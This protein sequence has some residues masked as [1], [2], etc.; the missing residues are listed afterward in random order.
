MPLA[1]AM[2]VVSGLHAFVAVRIGVD[3]VG[4]WLVDRFPKPTDRPPG[5]S[6][7]PA[8]TATL[9]A[10]VVAIIAMIGTAKAVWLVNPATNARLKGLLARRPLLHDSTSSQSKASLSCM[11]ELS[12]DRPPTSTT[13]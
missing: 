6:V 12:Q 1:I 3:L 8:S 2:V 9:A 10:T 4:N 11:T 5:A 7:I 13:W